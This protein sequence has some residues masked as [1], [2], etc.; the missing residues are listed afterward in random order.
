MSILFKQRA[1]YRVV[2]WATGNIGTR[3]LRTVLEH[4]KLEL[5]GVYVYAENKEGLDAGELC[6][7]GPVGIK[8][9][10]NID[11]IIGLRPDCV[12]YMPLS[13]EVADVCKLLESG[14]NVVTTRTEFFNP[15]HLE[16]EDREQV[17]AACRRGGSSLHSNG[18]SPGFITEALPLVLTSLQRRLDCIHIREFADVS[19]RN[20]PDLLFDI[21]GFN[22]SRE[23]AS[24]EGRAWYLRSS[25]G[26][27]LEIVAEALGLSFDSIE[28]AGEV[29]CARKETR[30]AAGVIEAGKV[31]AQRTTVTGLRNGKPLM[32]FTA[33]WFVTRD[34]DADWNLRANGWSVSVEGDTPLEVE[35]GFPVPPERWAEVSPGLTAHRAVNA[36]PYVCDAAPGIRT[37]V[38][39]PPIIADLSVPQA[40]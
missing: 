5:V 14:A 29:A 33:N 9:T 6:G 23:E 17:E 30:I 7:L 11:D 34:I 25:F 10:R 35:I 37:S 13:P 32:T 15:A 24:S 20:S 36:V 39:L 19:S 1:P 21:M 16:A 2:Q 8:A 26:P 40:R 4:P 38:E 3:S 22:Q 18:S 31:A 27:S 28:A 12:L